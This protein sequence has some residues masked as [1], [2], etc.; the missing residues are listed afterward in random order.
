MSR[1]AFVE[2]AVRDAHQS[3]WATRMTTAMMLPIAP[4][5]DRVGFESIELVGGAVFDV[6][7]RYLREDPWERMRLMSQAIPNT[8]LVLTVRGQS[9]FTFEFFPDDVVELT[10]K[11]GARNGM[12][13]L[14]VYD[15][16]NDIRNLEVPV[17][18]AREAGL[19]AIGGLVYSLSPVHTDAYYRQKAEALLRLGVDAV[20]L[21]DPSGL[22]TPERVRTLVPVLRRALGDLPLQLHSH[23]MTG[24]APICYLEAIH[25]GV[26]VVH[27][28]I[29]PL[30]HGSSL[31]PTEW[32][33]MHSRRAGFDVDLDTQGLDEM[34][35][36]FSGLAR[37]EKK[38]L[39]RPV[40][41]DPF[42]YEHQMPGGMITN[43]GY[44]LAQMGI[45]DRLDEVL[46]EAAQVRRDLGFPVVVSPFAQHV[47]TQSV[48]NVVQGERYASSPDEVRQYVLGYYGEPA[49]PIDPEVMDRIAG[50][51]APITERPGAVL[52]PALQRVREER[53]PFASDED[54]LLAVFFN[55]DIV[56]QL[57]A[58][59]PIDTAYK[60]MRSLASVVRELANQKDIRS[61]TLVMGRGRPTGSD[62]G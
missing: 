53:G 29:S 20:Y 25:L 55:P 45:E 21:K 8:P 62:R 4:L 18:S 36:Y 56:A 10:I 14:L 35:A 40:E 3:L 46:E 34:A 48:I 61:F 37:R 1:L 11:C 24:L 6:C 49:G 59:R 17:R 58:A 9:L 2:E 16:L 47:V 51:E 42:H 30:A 60:P 50:D 31:P 32:M 43:L 41:Y 5:M 52:P 54:L 12:R 23:C 33:A 39:G 15:G 7:V 27:T 13:H 38:P 26:D 19:Y 57:F 22:L 44:Q 28:A